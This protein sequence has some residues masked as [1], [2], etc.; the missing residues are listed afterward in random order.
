MTEAK[1]FTRKRA[2]ITSGMFLGA[3][4]LFAVAG[5]PAIAIGLVLHSLIVSSILSP[6]SRDEMQELGVKG[7]F[8]KLPGLALSMVRNTASYLREDVTKGIKKS[9]NWLEQAGEAAF[10]SYPPLAQEVSKSRMPGCT[11]AECLPQKDIESL[12]LSL[13]NSAW[14]DD[15]AQRRS[16]ISDLAVG[17]NLLSHSQDCALSLRKAPV[18][19]LPSQKSSNLE[20]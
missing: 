11:G 5:P 17:F 15:A 10:S 3:L 12:R 8:S 14:T 7:L 9:I 4:S 2:Y 13:L 1:I 18:A 16:N 6:I 19:E 20:L